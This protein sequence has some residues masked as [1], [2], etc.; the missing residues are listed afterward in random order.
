MCTIYSIHSAGRT[1][2]ETAL[3]N[4]RMDVVALCFQ[5]IDVCSQIRNLILK[6]IDLV[7]VRLESSVESL[8]QKIG[9]RFGL[10]RRWRRAVETTVTGA[11]AIGLARTRRSHGRR[12][13]VLRRLL[14]IVH[15]SVLALRALVV[16]GAG[17]RRQLVVLVGV[18]LVV[19]AVG[20]GV[21]AVGVV[22]VR[23]AVAPGPAEALEEH[24]MA[25][26]RRRAKRS[27]RRGGQE[28]ERLGCRGTRAARVNGRIVYLS[29]RSYTG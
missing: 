23:L 18:L 3:V 10:S 24:G 6:V 11:V 27:V 5:L 4:P 25:G 29:K 12:S 13:V 2:S 17:G 26:K 14:A 20:L 9:K 21:V 1:R 8:G 28:Y 7:I 19:G 16:E 15:A 22:D